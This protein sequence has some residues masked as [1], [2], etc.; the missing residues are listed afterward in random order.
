MSSAANHVQ[1]SLERAH[2]LVLHD[3]L[4]RI[5][6]RDQTQLD[7]IERQALHDLECYLEKQL[8]EPFKPDYRDIL[9]SARA[10]F[11]RRARQQPGG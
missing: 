1:I 8:V 9:K 6:D 11:G 7:D 2:A 5:D 4:A 10:E 3:W